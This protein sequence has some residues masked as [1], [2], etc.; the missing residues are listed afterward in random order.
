MKTVIRDANNKLKFIICH[1]TR[2]I[3]I[4]L[5]ASTLAVQEGVNSAKYHGYQ[6]IYV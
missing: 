5:N 4:S 1:T 6:V 3:V 2:T